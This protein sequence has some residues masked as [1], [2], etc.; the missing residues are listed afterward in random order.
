MHGLAV[1]NLL[2]LA[3]A[4][5]L[6]EIGGTTNVNLFRVARSPEVATPLRAVSRQAKARPIQKTIQQD[7]SYRLIE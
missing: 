7:H 4:L 5:G 1:Q 6:D 3:L 2:Q